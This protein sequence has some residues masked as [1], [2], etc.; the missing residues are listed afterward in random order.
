MKRAYART[1]RVGDLIQQA[2]ARILL[3]DMGNKQFQLVTIISVV[4]SRDLSYAKIYVTAFT[5]DAEKIKETVTALNHAAK[6]IRHQL[7]KSVELRIV[8]ELKFIYDESI[9]TGSR[10]DQLIHDNDNVK[11]G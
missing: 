8:P 1:D 3:N 7:A 11:N 4:V 2:L 5:D 9:A 6:P 10:I